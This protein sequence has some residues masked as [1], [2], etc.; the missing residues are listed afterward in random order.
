MEWI[1]RFNCAV[2]YIE[3]NIKEPINLE[4]VSK[5]ACYLLVNQ[6]A[7]N[8]YLLFLLGYNWV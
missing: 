4:E 3:E 2:N 5:I 6:V 7:N 1:E 8:Q